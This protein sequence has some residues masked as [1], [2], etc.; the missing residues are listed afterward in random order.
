MGLGCEVLGIV[1]ADRYFGL[2]HLPPPRKAFGV[3]TSSKTGEYGSNHAKFKGIIPFLTFGDYDTVSPNRK[4]Y[5]AVP[6]F[7]PPRRGED[8]FRLSSEIRKVRNLL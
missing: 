4:L 1:G 3:C 6:R 8:T 2:D 5:Q 7:H